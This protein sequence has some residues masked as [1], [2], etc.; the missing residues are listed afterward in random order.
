V[1]VVTVV[2]PDHKDAVERELL[3]L[4]IKHESGQKLELL[5]EAEI[6][7]AKVIDVSAS[8]Y[9]FELTG[10]EDKLEAFI[11]VFGKYGI[12]ELV[13][14]GKVAMARGAGLE[15]QNSNAAADRGPKSEIGDPKF[16][17]GV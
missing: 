3:L 13:R 10:D 12:L 9:T 6:F 14:S 1:D 8:S 16:N 2:A 4:K 15:A 7:R 5:K 17:A 11:N